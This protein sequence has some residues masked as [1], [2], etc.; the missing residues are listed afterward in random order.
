MNLERALNPLL[1]VCRTCQIVPLAMDA[2]IERGATLFL[3]AFWDL[4]TLGIFVALPS[5]SQGF[6]VASS[7]RVAGV[8]CLSGFQSVARG[9]KRF[10]LSS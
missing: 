5:A 9:K 2:D 8:G 1:L 3:V 4:D 6:D 10:E 7:R